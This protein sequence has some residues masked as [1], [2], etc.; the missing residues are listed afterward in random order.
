MPD[1]ALVIG[2]DNYGP[3]DWRLGGAVRDAL[4]FARWLTTHGGVRPENLLLL[5]SPTAGASLPE[6]P[7][8]VVQRGEATHQAIIDAV[9]ELQSAAIEG[10]AGDR[11]WVYYAGHGA[12][13]RWSPEPVLI[14]VDFSDPQRHGS[15]LIGFSQVIPALV[16]APFAEQLFLI[17]A[18]RDFALDNYRPPAVRSSVGAYSPTGDE[19]VDIAEERPRQ[20]VLYSVA[21]GKRALELGSGVWTTTLLEG[22][23]SRSYQVMERGSKPGGGL[24][25]ELRLDAMSEWLRRRV[26]ERIARIP[27]AAQSVQRPEYVPDPRG[28]DP[29]LLAY[30]LDEAPRV[31][32][33]VFVDPEIAWQTCR[34]AVLEY[35]GAGRER[36]TQISGPPIQ[37][38]ASFSLF[39]SFYSFRAEAG[40]YGLISK[41]WT[42][43][44]PPTVELTLEEVQEREMPEMAPP[45]APQ[46]ASFSSLEAAS[47]G[48][49]GMDEVPADYFE[50]ATDGIGEDWIEGCRVVDPMVDPPPL[51]PPPLPRQGQ[52]SV[53]FP[54]PLARIELFGG[55][56]PPQV[57]TGSLP[58]QSLTPG[59]YR[60]RVRLPGVPALERSIEVRAGSTQDL[61][62]EAPAPQLGSRHLEW[63][64]RLGM[65]QDWEDKTV[66]PSESLGIVG[67][68]RLASLLAF[69]AYAAQ[70]DG[71]F[72]KL[73]AFGVG[74]LHLSPGEAGVVALVGSAHEGEDLGR[75]LRGCR[76]V[77]RRP[78]GEVVD[79]GGFVTLD[80]MPAAAQHL[81]VL[82]G[83]S[84]LHAEIHLGEFAPTRY[85][86]AALPGRV[87]VL[88][89]VAESNGSVEVQQYLLPAPGS[90][91][92]PAPDRE[93]VESLVDLRRL[94]MAQTFYAAGRREAALTAV[95]SEEL[96]EKNLKSLLRGKWLDPLLGCLAGYVLVGNGRASEFLGRDWPDG[97]H[98]ALRNLL[99]Y[100]PDLSDVHVLAGLCDP[101]EEN[102]PAHFERALRS[103]LPV[104]SEGARALAAWARREGADLPPEIAE[105]LAHLLP[106]SPWTAWAA[107]EPGEERE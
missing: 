51:A 43:D 59:I 8:G 1:T 78:G 84:S 53:S 20:Y 26:A 24:R 103:G 28:G 36:E 80:G 50:E 22:L 63:L 55:N 69:A 52:L 106:G 27:N 88:V 97:N 62:L 47:A 105:P 23:G 54:D 9:A 87:S 48:L 85:A 89:A 30:A 60:L 14:P 37:A 61:D 74:K 5:S 83:P 39:P 19:D 92:V 42:V 77:L 21:P 49:D 67:G 41:P 73:R 82:A 104:F 17:D 101:A 4:T 93:Y 86:L 68:A 34:L 15:R 3:E 65:I 56:E 25:W 11:L 57:G 100:F 64:G 76:I 72:Q 40:R 44:D 70:E 12:S 45:P 29:L 66:C 10:N 95:S 96:D 81:T 94:E 98:S 16:T 79:D 13:V 32:V 71:R 90:V 7:A 33:E 31:Q 91:P 99:K 38:P 6:I 107:P 58:S 75:F 2:I 18:C 35:D 46:P 102:R